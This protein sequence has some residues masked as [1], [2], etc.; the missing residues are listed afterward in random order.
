MRR[1]LTPIVMALA[2]V[3]AGGTISSCIFDWNLER[4]DSFPGQGGTIVA[5]GTSKFPATVS[6][7][8]EIREVRSVT[9]YG[10]VHPNSQELNIELQAPGGFKTS[11]SQYRGTGSQEFDGDYVFVDLGSDEGADTYLPTSGAILSET[12]EASTDLDEFNGKDTL[13]TWQILVT[14]GGL[15]GSLDNWTLELR[16]KRY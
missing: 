6:E 1:A 2:I 16:Y 5:G 7:A 8:A 10:L 12:Y 9:L 14:N 3:V 11:L 13:G 15:T 4:T